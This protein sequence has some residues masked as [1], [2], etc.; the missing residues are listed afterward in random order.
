MKYLTIL[1]LL[2]IL[3][4][5]GKETQPPKYLDEVTYRSYDM[6]GYRI[7]VFEV[8]ECEYLFCTSQTSITHKANCKNPEHKLT[9]NN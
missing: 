8:E 7:T 1:L 5:G 3:G 9:L 6:N 2:L 4:C